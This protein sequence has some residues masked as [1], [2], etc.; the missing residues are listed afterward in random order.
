LN[1]AEILAIVG[2][3]EVMGYLK[4]TTHVPNINQYRRYEFLE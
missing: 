1:I 2:N 4:D 3:T